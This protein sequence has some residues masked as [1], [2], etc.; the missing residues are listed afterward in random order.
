MTIYM[1]FSQLNT[2]GH[3]RFLPIRF[4]SLLMPS[5]FSWAMLGLW[6]F[7][8]FLHFLFANLC[9]ALFRVGFTFPQVKNTM[10]CVS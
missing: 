2:S 8:C 1:S 3:P 5:S 7:L 6:K 9:C 4:S 10:K